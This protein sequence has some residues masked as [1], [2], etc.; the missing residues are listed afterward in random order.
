VVREGGQTTDFATAHDRLEPYRRQDRAF[1]D[2]ILGRGD[3]IRSPWQDAL[4]THALA[5]AASRAAG[6]APAPEPVPG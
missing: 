3:H 1:L 5:L 2:A 4:R 6:A